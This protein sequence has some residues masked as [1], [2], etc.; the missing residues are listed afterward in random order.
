MQGERHLKM[1]DK[2]LFVQ[3]QLKLSGAVSGFSYH[4]K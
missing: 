2:L 3:H 4:V 1:A